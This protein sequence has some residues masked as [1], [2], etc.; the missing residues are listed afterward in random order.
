MRPRETS[1][2]AACLALT[3]AAM[4][5]SA[6]GSSD[7]GSSGP[8]KFHND[9]YPFTF[10]YPNTFSVN[11]NVTLNQNLG[12][13]TENNLALVLDDTN[14]IILQT[15]PLNVAVT[16]ANLDAAK[17]EFDA[18]VGKADPSASGRPTEVGGFPA[19]EYTPIAISSIPDG[20]S[21][22]TF[23]F[24]GRNEYVINCQSTPDHR[25]QMD[26][27]CDQAV[28]TLQPA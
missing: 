2:V 22:I 1:L 14:G 19:L 20:Q 18:L 27:A 10:E 3:I 7:S 15:A 24:Q 5:L 8:A 11:D 4:G 12:T 23:L 25:S 6:C 21:Q 26:A 16:K 9:A 13:K 17:R 28:S